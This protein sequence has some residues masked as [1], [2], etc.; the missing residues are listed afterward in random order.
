M[1]SALVKFLKEDYPKRHGITDG[2]EILVRREEPHRPTF[3][4]SDKKETIIQEEGK[5]VSRIR[6]QGDQIEVIDFE[7]YINQF[8]EEGV[9][10]CD[11]VI[12]SIAGNAFILFNELT[13]AL[14]GSIDKEDGKRAKAYHQLEESIKRFCEGEWDLLDKYKKRVALFSFRYKDEP[15]GEPT[16]K[17]R[18]KFRKMQVRLPNIRDE[19]PLPHGFTFEQRLYPMPYIIE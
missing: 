3:E 17:T 7:G 4:I 6:W 15:I 10:R 19:Q 12:D 16:K 8:G 18:K 2:R 11:F 5:G 13:H 9:L 1:D 14:K